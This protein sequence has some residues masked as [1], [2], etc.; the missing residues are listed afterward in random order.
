MRTDWGDE[1]LQHA[2]WSVAFNQHELYW[3]PEHVAQKLQ[4]FQ[5]N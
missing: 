1:I 4:M 3:P 2:D 5:A